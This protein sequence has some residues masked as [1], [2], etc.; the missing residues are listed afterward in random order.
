MVKVNVRNNQF[1]NKGD[2]LFEIDDADYLQ[3]QKR[4][5]LELQDMQLSL[6]SQ[7]KELE[8]YNI[9]SPIDGVVISKSY[10]AGGYHR[11]QPKLQRLPL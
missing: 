9:K 2:I 10:K 5:N 3:A 8:N 7:Y 6:E 11:Q 1:V 4:T